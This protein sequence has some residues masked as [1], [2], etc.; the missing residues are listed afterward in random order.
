MLL[1]VQ[2]CGPSIYEL[3]QR[4]PEKD[5]ELFD[6]S[7]QFMTERQQQRFLRLPD[8][9]SRVRFVEELHI[10]DRLA[11]FPP[12]IQE[13]I[14]SQQV[15]PGMDIRALILSWGKPERIER[16]LGPDGERECWYFSR[17][18]GDNVVEKK[19]YILRGVVIE[20]E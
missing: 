2:G 1:L 8:S 16:G 3:Y 20:V 12:H 9:E 4:L 11:R 14:L 7:R 6:R 18:V 19:V 17:G 10:A 15:V 5:K 13:A